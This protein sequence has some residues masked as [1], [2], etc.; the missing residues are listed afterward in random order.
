VPENTVDYTAES[1]ALRCVQVVL[2]LDGGPLAVGYEDFA[3]G[4]AQ[5]ADTSGRPLW[6]QLVLPTLSGSAQAWFEGSV[7]PWSDVEQ[8]FVDWTLCEHVLELVGLGGPQLEEHEE[9]MLQRLPYLYGRGVTRTAREVWGRPCPDSRERNRG[10]DKLQFFPTVAFVPFDQAYPPRFWTVR[11]TI[12]VIRNVV[13]TVRLPDL[14]WSDRDEDFDYI[15]GGPLDV[16]ARYFPFA[17]DIAAEDIAEAIALHQAS[18]AREVSHRVRPLLT[19][20]ERRWAPDSNGA[21]RAGRREALNDAHD[22]TD[23]TETLFQLDRQVARLL[24]RFGPEG[25]V[26]EPGPAGRFVPSDIALRYRFALDELRSLEAHCRLASDAVGRAIASREHE[27]RERFHLVAGLAASAILIPTL[28]ASI[29]GAD[30]ALPAED[31]PRGFIA[32]L[33]FIVAFALAGLVVISEAWLR[34]WLPSPSRLRYGPVRIAAA[35]L[36]VAAFAGGLVAVMTQ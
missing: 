34:G 14:R 15:L 25:R 4:R 6:V 18:T 9:R 2:W 1:V 28:V 32:L 26:E 19:K 29:Y 16:P 20:I 3:L 13:V 27:E 12:G 24:R 23:I 22:L 35:I 30:V 31:T 33:L 7:D 8:P 17:D 21:G 5:E 36:A 10:G 11:V